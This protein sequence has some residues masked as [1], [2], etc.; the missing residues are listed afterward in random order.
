MVTGLLCDQY[1]FVFGYATVLVAVKLKY[2]KAF[3]KEDQG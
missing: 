3:W 1:S 2:K